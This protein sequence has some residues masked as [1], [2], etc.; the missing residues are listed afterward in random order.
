[1]D[2]PLCQAMRDDGELDER[3]ALAVERMFQEAQSDRSDFVWIAV[4]TPQRREVE[5]LAAVFGLPDLWVDDA[6]NPRQRAKFEVARD[7]SSALVVFKLLEY[8]ESTSDIETG[9]LAMFVGDSYLLTVRWGAVGALAPVR[10]SLVARPEQLALGPLAAAHAI[11]DAIVDDYIVAS[12]EIGRDIDAIEE[13]VFSPTITDDSGAIY[14]LKRENLEMRR[15]V[16]P[17][18]PLA[19]DLVGRRTVRMPEALLEYMHDVGDHLLRVNDLVESYDSLLLTML[20][21]SNA[22]QGL[23]QN[24]DMR[25]IAAYAAILAFP[26][27]IAGIYGM[28]FDHMPELH[29]RAGY[30]LVLAVMALGMTVIYRAFKRSGW[31]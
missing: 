24:I 16:V 23:Q 8:V 21:A 31:L 15:A 5:R 30:P 25:K 14:R 22:R 29:S 27:A 20:A 12:E 11:A 4:A 17:L 6:L 18:V 1:M 9:Q 3:T 7:R 10:A 26:T 19:Q 2:G 13:V 28:N